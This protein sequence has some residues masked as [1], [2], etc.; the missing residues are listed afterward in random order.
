MRTT[1]I[2]AQITTVEDKIA[3]SLNLTQILMLMFP[4]LWTAFLYILIPPVMALPGYK[5]TLTLLV[6]IISIILAIRIKNK[7][8]L[9]WLL[10]LVRFQNRPK[11]YLANKNSLYEREL[12]LPQELTKSEKV[13]SESPVKIVDKKELTIP[14]LVRLESLIESGK[15]AVRYQVGKK[16]L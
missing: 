13:S 12:D 10:V 6:T 3:G 14:E 16:Q 8:V 7:L 1:I 5:L 4:I 11:Y 2:P 9:E 15:L